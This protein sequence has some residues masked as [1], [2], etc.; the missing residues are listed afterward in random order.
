[1]NRK[2]AFP[3]NYFEETTKRISTRSAKCGLWEMSEEAA[4]CGEIWVT[5]PEQRKNN[6][7]S[8]SIVSNGKLTFCANYFEA[9]TKC[10]CTRYTKCGL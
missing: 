7:F 6:R 10:I 8:Q 1:M 2:L 3:A 5:L 9:E 4:K